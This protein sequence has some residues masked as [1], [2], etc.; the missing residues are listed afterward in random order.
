MTA[1]KTR[2]PGNYASNFVSVKDF[3]AVGDGVADDT[4]AYLAANAAASTSIYVPEG[5]YLCST[6]APT[7][8]TKNIIGPGR[9]IFGGDYLPHPVRNFSSASTLPTSWST[10][11]NPALAMSGSQVGKNGIALQTYVYGTNTAG[12][13]PTGYHNRQDLAS[14]NLNGVFSSGYNHST[15]DTEG[16]T[17]VP[18]LSS[19]AVHAGKG[20]Y[21]NFLAGGY[22]NNPDPGRNSHWLAD[23]ALTVLAGGLSTVTPSGNLALIELTAEDGGHAITGSGATFHL[24]RT[25]AIP[26]PNTKQYVWQGITANSRGAVALDSLFQGTGLSRIGLDFSNTTFTDN[27]TAIALK[28]GQAVNFNSVNTDPIG[29]SLGTTPGTTSLYMSESDVSLIAKVDGQTALSIGQ[30]IVSS[31]G[32]GTRDISVTTTDTSGAAIARLKTE[33]TGSGG[34]NASVSLYAGEGYT[35]LNT[36]TNSPLL[37]ATNNSEKVRVTPGGQLLIGTFTDGASKLVVNDN[38]IQINTAKTPASATDTGTTGQIAWDAN[39]VYVCTATNTWKRTAI[40]TW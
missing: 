12:L 26:S 8:I 24:Y 28:R 29:V 33:Y 31:S 11:G 3:G 5:E 23:P 27:N 14:I 1:I 15:T 30:S 9:T 32:S 40:A 6:L 38:S 34:T 2:A 22:I 37:I 39:Y 17:G 13:E 10:V 16:R 4:A 7:N 18:N 21:F 35:I 20:D 25:A 19:Y 36:T